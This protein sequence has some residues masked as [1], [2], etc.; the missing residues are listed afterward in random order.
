MF[1]FFYYFLLLILIIVCC[2]GC[3][4]KTTVNFQIKND[5][6]FQIDFLSIEP[7][8]NPDKVTG[9]KPNQN[10]DYQIDMSH[11]PK[12]D[13]S[14]FL[15]FRMNDEQHL[16]RFGYY[17]NGWPISDLYELTIKADTILIK[18]IP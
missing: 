12:T 7:N 17:T 11:V 8:Q 1:L 9:L 14:Y 2:S 5:T 10:L 4:N 18:E 6:T 16:K 13:G 3:E 15:S